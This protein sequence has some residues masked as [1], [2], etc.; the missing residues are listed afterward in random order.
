MD[1]ATQSCAVITHK[2]TN[3]LSFPAIHS[4]KF[5]HN[6]SSAV[7][8]CTR[9]L[10]SVTA[11]HSMGSA[12]QS[13][14]VITHKETN[15]LS[16]PAIHSNKFC[17]N[18]SSAVYTCTRD[19][20]SV[21][22]LHSMGSATQSCAVITHKETNCLSFPA[23]HSNKFCHNKSSAVYTCMPSDLLSPDTSLHPINIF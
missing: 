4:N 12:T 20:F 1:L 11:L 15:C 5:C 2:E 7:Y 8:T 6:K 13:C 3:C 22:A 23:I 14:A 21:T 10:F 19:L 9:D 17:H 16:F 18:K